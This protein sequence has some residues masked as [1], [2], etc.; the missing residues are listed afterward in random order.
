MAQPSS[1]D[2]LI[3]GLFGSVMQSIAGM[4]PCCPAE[5]PQEGDRRHRT[6][7]ASA[8]ASYIETEAMRSGCSGTQQLGSRA[9]LRSTSKGNCP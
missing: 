7:Y 5:P 1:T 4:Q 9:Q 6:R 8:S 3:G 2:R